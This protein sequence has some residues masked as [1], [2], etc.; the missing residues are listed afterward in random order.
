MRLHSSVLEAIALHPADR[1]GPQQAENDDKS[2]NTPAK[3]R[4]L[5]AFASSL[6]Q[7]CSRFP[8]EVAALEV[9]RPA[10]DL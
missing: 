7:L 5:R 1:R 10:R 8:E 2:S 4:L 3:D 9:D 6:E